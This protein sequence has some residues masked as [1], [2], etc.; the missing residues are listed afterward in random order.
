MST[1]VQAYLAED[2]TEAEEIESILQEAGIDSQLESAVDH[3]PAATDDAPVKV[4]VPEDALEGAR[5]AIESMTEVD[6][7]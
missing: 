3:H 4:L 2:I 5:A 1:W 6:D 7:V